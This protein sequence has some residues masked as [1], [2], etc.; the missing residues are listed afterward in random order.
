MVVSKP[1]VSLKNGFKPE[2][3]IWSEVKYLG[4]VL[5]VPLGIT[6]LEL[7]FTNLKNVA[8]ARKIDAMYRKQ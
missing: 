7:A 6:H 3:C 1:V 2:K 5:V 8:C 4:G